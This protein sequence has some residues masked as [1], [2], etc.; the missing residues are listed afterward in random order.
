MHSGF[1][2][3]AIARSVLASCGQCNPPPLCSP[4]VTGSHTHL[5]IDLVDGGTTRRLGGERRPSLPWPLELRF[6]WWL[7]LSPLNA[8]I[9]VAFGGD[10]T[11]VAP[12]EFCF[13]W[14][15]FMLYS[16]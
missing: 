3:A 5:P 8:Q 11:E 10:G 16:H 6:W 4:T 13:G 1:C 9:L 2:G 15:G 7:V 14:W 12:L